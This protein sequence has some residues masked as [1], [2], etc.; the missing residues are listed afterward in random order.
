MRIQ[1]LAL[2]AH[3][4]GLGTG[5]YGETEWNPRVSQYGKI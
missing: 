5:S 4:L 2:G 3:Y 1:Y